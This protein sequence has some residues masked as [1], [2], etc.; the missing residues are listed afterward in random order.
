[1]RR[2]SHALPLSVAV[3]VR[4]MQSSLLNFVRV[5]P[6]SSNNSQSTTA[7]AGASTPTPTTSSQAAA[8]PTAAAAPTPPTSASVDD[9]ETAYAALGS[10]ATVSR[11]TATR[12]H[13]AGG[14]VGDD[15]D[16]GGGGG[17]DDDGGGDG[18]DDGG[19]TQLAPKARATTTTKNTTAT[20][21]PSSR[22][23]VA[24]AMNE[25]PPNAPNTLPP[26]S[27]HAW[28]RD[29]NIRDAQ[30]RRRTAA[31]R[32]VVFRALFISASV[33]SLFRC[34]CCTHTS[35]RRLLIIIP[36]HV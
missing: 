16:G 6:R 22:I 3:C 31:V 30:V 9:V 24:A 33:C 20:N 18:S 34:L 36:S 8:S 7:S 13:D 26:L 29:E 12:D 2:S 19:S 14:A 35:L 4:K 23:V 17:G 21:T 11:R 15:D 25:T 32:G 28:L 5:T 10:G 27:R 1:M